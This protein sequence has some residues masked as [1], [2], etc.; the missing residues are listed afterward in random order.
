M[1]SAGVDAIPP[2]RVENVN[3]GATG[4]R[5]FPASCS[6][7]MVLKVSKLCDGSVMQGRLCGVLV[8]LDRVIE[9]LGLPT[10]D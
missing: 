1:R 8:V 9:A 3:L 5:I 7:I 4:R 6:M 2:S 10:G